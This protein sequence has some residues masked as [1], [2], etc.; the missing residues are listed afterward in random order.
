MDLNC[1]A[2]HEQK[3]VRR[4]Q[5]TESYDSCI[6]SVSVSCREDCLACRL[7]VRLQGYREESA[8]ERA[9]KGIEQAKVRELSFWGVRCELLPLLLL[10]S[11]AHASFLF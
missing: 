7:E 9:N 2:A 3:E 5:Y 8:D 6:A 4:R 10:V 1:E 11:R